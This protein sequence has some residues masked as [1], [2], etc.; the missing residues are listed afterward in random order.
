MNPASARSNK[1][2][3]A[4]RARLDALYAQ[5]NRPEHVGLD[6]LAAVLRFNKPEDQELVGFIAAALAFGNVKIITRSVDSVLRRFPHPA[7]DLMA[8]SESDLTHMFRDFRHRFVDGEDLAAL[9]RGLRRM[10]RE[11]GSLRAGFEAGVRPAEEDYLSALTRFTHDLARL[12][13]FQDN[14]LVADP[15][16]GS[17]CKRLCLFLRWMIR[18]DAVD[19]GP[20]AGL[21]P[22]RLLVPLD[23]H[24]H[25]ISRQLGFTT[26]NAADL[27]T[28]QE[29][30][31]AFRTLNPEDP[32]RYDFALTR[33]GIQ[34]VRGESDLLPPLRD[35]P[36]PRAR[37]R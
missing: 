30:T 26:R 21:D 13:A 28:V 19:P 25:R 11:Y 3:R 20:W 37:A 4:L 15:A 18:R 17:A 8:V 24:M 33:L 16:R 29:V 23:T 35:N 22:A 2:M 27:R 34:R 32:V 9:L 6:P 10:M 12:G 7:K 36:P 14:Y 5:F 31:G 1:R